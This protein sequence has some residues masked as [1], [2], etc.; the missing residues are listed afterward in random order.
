[1]HCTSTYPSKPE[2]M[3]LKCINT[4]KER[5]PWAKIG[6]SNHYPGLSGMVMAYCYGA[7]M[8]EL[9]ITLSRA[10]WGSDQAASIEPRGLF[11]LA[12]RLEIMDKMK[13]DGN[14]VV[15]G[16]ELPIIAKLRR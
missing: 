9:H 2:E 1:M 12:G 7:E 4:M 16:S 8:I 3:N 11:D 14:K 5:Y 15:Y 10:M 6:F 13:G